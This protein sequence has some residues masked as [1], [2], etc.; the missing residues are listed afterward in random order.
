[1]TYLSGGKFFPR[2]QK[3]NKDCKDVWKIKLTVWRIYL[4]FF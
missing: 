2:M 1:M 3:A 4:F